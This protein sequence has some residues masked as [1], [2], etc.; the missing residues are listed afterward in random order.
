MR[1]VYLYT[2]TAAFFARRFFVKRN[3][4]RPFRAF[5][6][7]ARPP[8]PLVQDLERIDIPRLRRAFAA[9]ECHRCLRG[10]NPALAAR[11]ARWRLPDPDRIL[12]SRRKWVR[13]NSTLRSDNIPNKDTSSRR[14]SNKAS[15]KRTRCGCDAMSTTIGH[16]I[17]AGSL[18]KPDTSL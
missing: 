10:S 8:R 6:E 12:D 9:R 15:R 1:F 14:P 11:P 18:Q 16:A 17:A 7:L 5:P 2:K 4:F 13:R 3:E